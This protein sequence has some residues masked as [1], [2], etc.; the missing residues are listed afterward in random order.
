MFNEHWYYWSFDVYL[1]R[2][3]PRSAGYGCYSGSGAKCAYVSIDKMYRGM[4][5]QTSLCYDSVSKLVGICQHDMIVHKLAIWISSKSG[6]SRS[7]GW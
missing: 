3:A 5:Q 6:F 2:S 4:M 7:R 1:A